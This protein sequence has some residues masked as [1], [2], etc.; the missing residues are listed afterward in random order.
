MNVGLGVEGGR[1]SRPLAPSA[2]GFGDV[3]QQVERGQI[4]E[5]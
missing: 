4:D 3:G 1:L 5:P 2:I